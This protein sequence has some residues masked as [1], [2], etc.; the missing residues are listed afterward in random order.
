[1]MK[2]VLAVCA[3]VGCVCIARVVAADEVD[4][5]TQMYC[6]FF[7]DQYEH[8]TPE[9]VERISGV[10]GSYWFT[11]N[12]YDYWVYYWDLDQRRGVVVGFWHGNG[13]G[14]TCSAL[15]FE[16]TVHYSEC[17][18]KWRREKRWVSPAQ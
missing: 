2:A 3:A 14:S 9:D 17:D 12:E 11:E 10:G 8:A 6:R 16:P 13:Y 1:M 18:P 5:D 15:N 4:I 7:T